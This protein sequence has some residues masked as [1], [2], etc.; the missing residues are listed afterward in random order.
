MVD[1]YIGETEKNLGR[2]FDIAGDAQS[3]LL[4]DEADALLG[5]RASEI[6]SSTDRYANLQVN[7]LLGRI[8]SYDGV[9]IMTSN[10][11]AVMDEALRRRVSVNVAF[12]FPAEAEREILWRSHI[13]PQAPTTDDIDW[14]ALAN[15]FE[16][17]G[18]H[19]KNA[20]IRAAVMAADAA[21]P[22]CQ[23]DLIHAAEVEYRHLG[24]A[25]RLR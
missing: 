12:L 2:V 1:K 17:S 11:E 5:K 6:R 24:R 21:R 8:E 15:R 9:I 18:G 13:P 10:M 20:V 14:R 23:D 7:Y 22:M 19:I 25:V 3:V 4:F 16:L